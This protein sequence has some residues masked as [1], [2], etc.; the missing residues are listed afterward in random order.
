MATVTRTLYWGLAQGDRYKARLPSLLA[1]P[2][3]K[4]KRRAAGLE[5]LN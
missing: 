4:G 3:G 1:V 2:D 5:G